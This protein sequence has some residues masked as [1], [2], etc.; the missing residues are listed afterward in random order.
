MAIE[1]EYFK[2]AEFGKG[3]GR[4]VFRSI[5]NSPNVGLREMIS[6]FLDQY[7]DKKIKLDKHTCKRFK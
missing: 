3:V 4:F 2:P 7:L 1:E 6:N 5:Y